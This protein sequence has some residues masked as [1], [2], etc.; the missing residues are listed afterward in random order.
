[1]RTIRQYAKLAKPLSSI[2]RGED[3]RVS[4]NDSKKKIINMN[5]DAIEAFGKI[6][7]S[8]VSDKVILQFPDFNKEFHLTTDAS[9]FAIGAMLSQGDRPISFICRTLSKAEENYAT[10]QKE[11]LAIIWALKALR[12]YLY[13]RTKIKIYTDHQPLT[14]SLSSWNG[15]SKV[16]RWKAYLE[17]YNY[18]L[19][20]KPGKS[21][22]VADALSRPSQINTVISTQHSAESSAEN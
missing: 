15:N 20:Y 18:E 19:I 16:K 6:K 4:K 5:Q 2:L 3:G 1:M 14:Y 9:D 12:N 22:V 17:E 11:M 10:N 8:L 7:H 21:N 13:G